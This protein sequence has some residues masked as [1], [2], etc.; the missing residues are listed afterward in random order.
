VHYLQQISDA[1][2]NGALHIEPGIWINVPET[3]EPAAPPSVVRL[4]TIP[5]GDALLAQGDSRTVAGPPTIE[6]ADSTPISNADGQPITNA[7]Y[8]AP[9]S[10]TQPP[11]GIPEHAIINPNVVLTDAI[12]KQTI[13]ETVVLS[14]S[15][16]TA[17]G[18]IQGGIQNIP[19]VVKNANATRMNATFWIEKVHDPAAGEFMQLQYTQTVMLDFLDIQWPHITV[20]TLVKQ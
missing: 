20:A 10:I 5:H 15:T 9:F 7:D 18:G 3:T 11:P 8:L 14:I 4:A 6:A 17:V 19:F 2:T 16:Q 12:A 1:V 13:V